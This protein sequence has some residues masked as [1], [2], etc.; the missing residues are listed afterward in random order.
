MRTSCR[1]EDEDEDEDE[2]AAWFEWLAGMLTVTVD[3][4]ATVVVVFEPSS[5]G[6]L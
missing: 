3:E 1:D 2:A 4:L 5:F 6:S